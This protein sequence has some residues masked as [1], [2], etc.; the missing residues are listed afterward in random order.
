MK[1]AIFLVLLA[2]LFITFIAV[3]AGAHEV[4]VSSILAAQQAGAPA[5]GM[6]AMINHPDNTVAITAGEIVVLRDAGVPESVLMAIWEQVPVPE[7]ASGSVQPDDARLV[8]LVLLIKSGMTEPIITEQVTK[9]GQTYR[10]STNDL[11]YLKQNGA[12]ELTIAALMA[13]RPDAPAT[14]LIAPAELVIDNLVLVNRGFWRRDHT[15]SM[16]VRGDTLSWKDDRGTEG[17]FQFQASGID[18]VWFTCEARP[19]ESFCHQINFKIVKGDRYRF[20]DGDRDTGSNASV[21]KVM[22]ALRTSFP[23]LNFATPSVGD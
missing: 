22:E 17:S 5:R 21:I 6:I 13:T 15:G 18:K 10:L 11:L 3:V 12:H 4:T 1:R 14:P 23:R 2:V 9:A 19:S 20:Q 16:V 8:D 7:A